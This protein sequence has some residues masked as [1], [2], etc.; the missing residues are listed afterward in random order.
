[1]CVLWNQFEWAGRVRLTIPDFY[2]KHTRVWREL[3]HRQFEPQP[4]PAQG[5]PFPR[6][7]Q[8][9]SAGIVEANLPQDQTSEIVNGLLG[10]MRNARRLHTERAVKDVQVVCRGRE[11]LKTIGR[12]PRHSLSL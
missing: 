6:F 10:F 5:P 8:S 3:F 7:L 4:T 1:M 9:M 11:W 2:Q 12:A